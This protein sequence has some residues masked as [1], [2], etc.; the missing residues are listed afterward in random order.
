MKNPISL[1]LLLCISILALVRSQNDSP[2]TS[3]YDK[4]TT[5]FNGVTFESVVAYMSLQGNN[6]I[7]LPV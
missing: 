7:T 3:Q 4:A 6:T 1:A 5:E 2:V